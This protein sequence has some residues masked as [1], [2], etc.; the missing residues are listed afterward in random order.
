MVATSS[1]MLSLR[2]E[3]P[4]FVLKDVVSGLKMDFEKTNGYQ[5]Y[6]ICFVCNHC[7]YVI[8]LLDDLVNKL[9][10]WHQNGISVVCICSNDVEK[11]PADDAVQMKILAEEKNFSF[12]Y[13]FDESQEVA[14]SFTAAC[15]PDFFLFDKNK[16]L[17]YR[18]QYD[19][20]RPSNNHAING[21]DLEQAVHAVLQQG[22]PP[23]NQIPSMGC[24]IKWKPGNEPSYFSS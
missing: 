15:T 5:A 8:H 22:D 12:P 10:N 9:N 19:S 7:P 18:G 14:K 2:T 23:S 24:N 11:Y 20:S 6:L 1:T 17:F 16:R 13:L 21:K 3:A 4:N